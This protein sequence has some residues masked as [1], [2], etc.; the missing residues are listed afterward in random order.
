MAVNPEQIVVMGH[1]AG[2]HLAALVSIDPDRLGKHRKSL[3]IIDGAILLD[4]AAYDL[5]RML[6]NP[7]LPDTSR[8]MHL[9]WA[10]R[11]ETTQ[12]DASPA[13]HVRENTNIPPFLILHTDRAIGIA[14]SNLL[15]ERLEDAG[16]PAMVLLCEDETHT[17]MNQD[18]GTPDHKPTE[19]IRIVLESLSQ[20]N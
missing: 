13:L 20:R 11:S 9:A 17:S 15:G 7:R 8:T 19:A 6:A 3:S 2:A 5:P 12:A 10:G 4:G 16:V 14:E 18:L 1:S